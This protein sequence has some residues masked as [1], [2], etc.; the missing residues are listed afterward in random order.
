MT[1]TLET[2]PYNYRPTEKPLFSALTFRHLP[3]SDASF[4]QIIFP[5]Y[6]TLQFFLHN[7]SV[8]LQYKQSTKILLYNFNFLNEYTNVKRN[9]VL[10]SN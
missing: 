4:Q 6:T 7:N 10:N 1:H 8:T 3:S 2:L 9:N 5:E